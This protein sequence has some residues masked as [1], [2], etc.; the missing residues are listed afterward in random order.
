[1]TA[2]TLKAESHSAR[3]AQ[4]LNAGQETETNKQE[5]REICETIMGSSNLRTSCSP[6]LTTLSIS[7]MA[8]FHSLTQKKKKIYILNVLL[9]I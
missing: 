8:K 1:M 9:Q 3:G 2:V 7:I 5:I 6:A 4:Y